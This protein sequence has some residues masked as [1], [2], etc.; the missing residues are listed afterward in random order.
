MTQ[1]QTDEY[2][3]SLDDNLLWAEIYEMWAEL[4]A[5]GK[6]HH[7]EIQKIWQMG[8][9]DWGINMYQEV[10]P[11]PDGSG[12]YVTSRW[13]DVFSMGKDLIQYF[14]NVPEVDIMNVFSTNLF[15]FLAG[16]MFLDKD[17]YPVIAPMTIKD[18]KMKKIA[19]GRGSE[20]E[21]PVVSFVERDKLLVLNK[22]NA[23]AIAGLYGPETD[24]WKGNRIALTGEKGNWFG[25]AGVR[26]VV[27]DSV[28]TNGNGR[29]RKK[30]KKSAADGIELPPP[31][32]TEDDVPWVEE[33][34]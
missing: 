10:W 16:E 7:I 29:R 4:D 30:A 26:V 34:S 24:D 13:H 14:N 31:E 17:G 18:V 32:M 5:A 28:P 6:P 8:N 22:T 12:Q 21:K 33:T 15:E 2:L 9:G 19:N 20:E 11:H 27:L 1:T 3:T 23:R 25:K